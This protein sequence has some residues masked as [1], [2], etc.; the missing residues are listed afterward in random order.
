MGYLLAIKCKGN[1]GYITGQGGVVLKTG[2]QGMTWEEQILMKYDGVVSLSIIDDSRVYALGNFWGSS[3][4]IIFTEDNV[5]W[6]ILYNHSSSAST[7][8]F[9]DDQKGFFVSHSVITC[10]GCG[11]EIVIWKT[12][13]GGNTWQNVYHDGSRQGYASANDLTF[14]SNNEFGY[15]VWGGWRLMKTP[16]TGEF[17][18]CEYYTEMDAINSENSTPVFNQQGDELQINSYSKIIDRVEL[19][20]VAGIKIMQQNEQT[21]MLNINVSNL[22]K[23]VYLVN[24][25]FSDKTSYYNKWVK[26]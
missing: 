24:V 16:Y 2:D 25:L 1:R 4:D 18:Y 10:M 20:T 26:N 19:I 3:T 6:H 14:S 13:D 23:G 22:P 7:I 17:K 9:Q 11:S 12:T 15:C 8:Y 5:N 21:K